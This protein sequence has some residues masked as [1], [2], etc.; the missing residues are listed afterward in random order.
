MLEKWNASSSFMLDR[1]TA[2]RRTT[3]GIHNHEVVTDSR[4]VL[5]SVANAGLWDFS[6]P[7]RLGCALQ[8]SYGPRSLFGPRRT[9]YFLYNWND[10][11]ERQC[12][13]CRHWRDANDCRPDAWLFLD[14]ST[15]WTLCWPSTYLWRWKHGA[16][17]ERVCWIDG[18][19]RWSNGIRTFKAIAYGP[20]CIV[21]FEQGRKVC[22]PF[23]EAFYAEETC[24]FLENSFPS[25]HKLRV[26]Q[27]INAALSMDR[28][29]MVWILPCIFPIQRQQAVLFN[30]RSDYDVV[31]ATNAIG[32]CLNLHIRRIVFA[33]C[34][35]YDGT[36]LTRLPVSE[37]KQIAGRAGRFGIT[38]DNG[39]VTVLQGKKDFE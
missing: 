7:E 23:W 29:R 5:W 21:I 34:T 31:V 33:E 15:V 37:V 17:R 1:Q 30:K 2:A 35:R 13:S 36:Q 8:S 9:S 27:G 19:R 10:E 38:E 11:H 26:P 22:R 16:N 14:E 25:R 3:S 32:R 6:S 24:H 39:L 12:P 20:R 18:G 4:C 28:Y